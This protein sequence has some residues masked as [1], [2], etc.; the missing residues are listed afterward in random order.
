MYIH[1][2]GKH[3]PVHIYTGTIEVQI[4]FPIEVKYCNDFN[5]CKI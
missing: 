1:V 3:V 5:A 2:I 4:D